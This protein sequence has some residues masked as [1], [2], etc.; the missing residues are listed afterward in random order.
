MSDFIINAISLIRREANKKF[1]LLSR[2]TRIE[3]V[4]E[5]WQFIDASDN[6]T[7]LQK[8]VGDHFNRYKHL[9]VVYHDNVVSVDGV[10]KPVRDATIKVIYDEPFFENE[11]ELQEYLS[12]MKLFAPQRNITTYFLN[13]RDIIKQATTINLEKPKKFQKV[14]DTYN[15]S[16][17]FLVQRQFD[18][19]GLLW[20]INAVGENQQEIEAIF[21]RKIVDNIIDQKKNIYAYVQKGNLRRTEDEN[22]CPAFVIGDLNK[23]IVY[24][25]SAGERYNER[26]LEKLRLEI[27]SGPMVIDLDNLTTEG[28]GNAENTSE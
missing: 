9:I 21:K 23:G 11:A 18:G 5:P 14:I 3:D 10:F 27:G 22:N 1:L 15:A 20:Y 19:D 12:P 28:D 6:E 2:S 17:H 8:T 16:E 7:E 4:D 13:Y 26:D 24:I 25:C